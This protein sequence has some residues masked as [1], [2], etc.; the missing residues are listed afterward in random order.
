MRIELKNRFESGLPADDDHP[1]RTGAWRPNH[2]EYDAFELEVSGDLP[3]DL[4]GVYLR[5]T[6][7]PLHDAIGRY[8]PFDGDG[9][10]HALYLD[11]GEVEYRNRFIR[12]DGFNAELAERAP[13]WAGLIESPKKSLRD[14]WGARTRLK[15]AS[16][17]DVVV[18]GGRAVTSF[19]QCGDLYEFD[20]RTL[21]Q[22]GK[23]AWVQQT[24]PGW[25]VSAHTKI[26]EASG[27]MLF[28]NYSKQ[29]PYMHYGVVNA[30]RQ[31]V[32]Y[33]PIP[34][35]GPRLPHD[36]AF[37]DNYAILN[38]F[39]LYWDPQ[40]LQ[41]GAHAVRFDRDLPS[42][43]GIIPRRGASHEIRWFEAEPTFVLHWINAFEAGDEVVLDGFFEENPDPQLKLD[44]NDKRSMFRMLDMHVV[45]A[46]PYRWRFNLKT[47][48]TK[49][50]YLDDAVSEFGMINSTFAGKPYRYVWATTMKPEWFLMNGLVRLDVMTGDKQTYTFP[51]G[52]FIS[53]S[54][55][56][57]RCGSKQE[58]DGYVMTLVTD[59][60]ED[61]SSALIFDAQDISRGPIASVALPQRI[62]VG[63]HSCW[64][65][66]RF[67]TE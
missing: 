48:E 55:M 39:P 24:T 64:S 20:P 21:E 62:C 38:D 52:V 30:A 17:T 13:L 42:R 36:M 22:L 35:P 65:D 11:N 33:V 45:G 28:F 61:T 41:A 31:L 8:H 59:M 7:N 14:G 3:D 50:G 57:P 66:K 32:H 51:E 43:F 10:L 54:P 37:T 23:S 53:E 29:P 4:A 18:H 56:A 6:E 12:T 25:G 40:A 1:Y 63:T 27:E 44:P 58:D 46:K 49:E 26:D 16:S 2:E 15:D 5:N 47:G 9:M 34:L 19:Y 67:L 60:N